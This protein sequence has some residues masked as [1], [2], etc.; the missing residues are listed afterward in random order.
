MRR[1]HFGRLPRLGWRGTAILVRQLNASKLEIAKDDG[2]QIVEIMSHSAG[3]LTHRLH[4]LACSR[5]ASC[6]RS[7]VASWMSARTLADRAAAAADNGTLDGL[8]GEQLARLPAEP[9]RMRLGSGLRRWVLALG[10]SCSSRYSRT[11]KPCS[12]LAP[13]AR[14]TSEHAHERRV[15]QPD[16]PGRV[17]DH[18]R[19][20]QA[21]RRAA[22]EQS[23]LALEALLS[24]ARCALRSTMVPVK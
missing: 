4:A 12:R 23:L 9:S 5:S 17:A 22:Q 2:Q 14:S 10:S 3:E 20:G 16:R 6:W 7:A 18:E 21:L 24:A 1:A 11:G 19:V 8:G 13:R 15:D